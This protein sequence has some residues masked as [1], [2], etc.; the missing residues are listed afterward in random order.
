MID[1]RTQVL[2]SQAVRQAMF[3]VL[4]EQRDEIIKRARAKLVA[5][6]VEFSDTDAQSVITPV[7]QDPAETHT[8]SQE[9]K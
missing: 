4:G 8:H 3:E 7:A 9:A 1:E 6:G 2:K 5:M